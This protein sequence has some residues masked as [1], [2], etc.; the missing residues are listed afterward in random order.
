[1]KQVV[2]ISG[3]GGTGKSTL[4]ASLS[5][6]IRHKALADCDVDAPNLH[7]LFQGTVVKK[8]DF[9]GAQIARIHQERC[10]GCGLCYQHC[11]FEAVKVAADYNID[12]LRCEG[13][14]ACIQVC[15]QG[16]LN[17]HTI[18]T[19]ETWVE[20]T[21]YGEFSH[22]KLKPGAEGSGKLVTA[23]KKNLEDYLLRK[24]K[25]PL[26]M[27]V[28]GSPGTGCSVIAS[29]TGADAAVVV[30]EPTLSGVSGLKR[31]L[32]VTKHFKIP[33][34]VC[35]NKYDLNLAVSKDVEEFCGDWG[36]Q[37]WGRIPFESKMNQALRERKTPVDFGGMPSVVNEI[38]KIAAQLIKI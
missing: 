12:P 28:D 25:K 27:L 9:F 5:Q 21:E 10:T 3:K 31:I 18:V 20:E 37:V 14:G 35:I 32:Q 34:Q 17:L 13:C 16:A 6:I 29:L 11:R 30:T 1:M 33:A 2:F 22:A 26:L 36:V 7:I 19:G 8:E 38:E 15:P 24:H 23:V 4:V